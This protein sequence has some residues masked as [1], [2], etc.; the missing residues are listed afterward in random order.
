[1]GAV[2]S[3]QLLHY[4]IIEGAPL[5]SYVF[6]QSLVMFFVAA[7]L[8]E[9]A[10]IFKIYRKE[11]RLGFPVSPKALYMPVLD[12]VYSVLVLAYICLRLPDKLA[13][14]SKSSTILSGLDKLDWISTN[15]TLDSKK[16]Q[17]LSLV[18]SLL[19]LCVREKNVDTFANFILLVNL[20]RVIQ[21]PLLSV[22]YCYSLLLTGPSI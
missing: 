21:V 15:V 3:Y 17:F 18:D 16:E 20:F 19:S 6:I 9:A 8:L 2:V 13:S 4:E 14:A 5:I 1:V 12:C 22:A 10:K 11:K 7:I